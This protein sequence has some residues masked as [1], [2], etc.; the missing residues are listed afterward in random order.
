LGQRDKAVKQY[1]KCAEV[2][3]AELEVEPARATIEL[4]EQLK[5]D[6]LRMEEKK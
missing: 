5:Q 1:R 3:E 6:F 2:L 4:Y